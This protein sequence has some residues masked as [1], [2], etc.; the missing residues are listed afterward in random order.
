[1]MM[2]MMTATSIIIIITINIIIIIIIKDEYNVSN[3]FLAAHCFIYLGFVFVL[4]FYYQLT[5]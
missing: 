1:M 3:L 5:S 2:M 4:F